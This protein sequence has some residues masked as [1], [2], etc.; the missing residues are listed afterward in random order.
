[1]IAHVAEA[2]EGRGRVVLKLGTTSRTSTVALAAAVRVAQ[3]FGSEIESLFIEDEAL[4]A[5]AGM[6]FAREVSLSGRERRPLSAEGMLRTMRATGAAL[7]REVEDAARAA[8]VRVRRRVLRAEPLAAIAIACADSGPWNIVALAEPFT[9]SPA[10]ELRD[11]LAAADTTGVLVAGAA[12]RRTSGGR[13]A[14]LLEDIERL[15]SKLRA[16]ER[17][18]R[19]GE[20]AVLVLGASAEHALWMEAHARLAIEANPHVLLDTLDLGGGMRPVLDWLR[21]RSGFLIAQFGGSLV[22]AE[23]SAPPALALVECPV[24]VVR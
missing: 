22:P 19:G 9:G 8:D 5:L 12:A 7:H 2:R 3:A 16:A 18:A 20:I 4:V 14:I 6:P 17:L 13:V 23:G 1:M 11:V 24:L 15:P 10:G 21:A